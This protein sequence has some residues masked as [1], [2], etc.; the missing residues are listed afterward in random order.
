MLEDSGY[1]HE[2]DAEWQTRRNMKAGKPPVEPLYT[3]ADADAALG[4]VEKAEYDRLVTLN[5]EMRCF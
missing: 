4:Y 5:D 2:K 1:I 3:L